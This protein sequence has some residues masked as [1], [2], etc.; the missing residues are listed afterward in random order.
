MNGRS[1]TMQTAA[2]LT[3]LMLSALAADAAEVKVFTSVALTNALNELAPEHTGRPGHEN[4]DLFRATHIRHA[5]LKA[6]H[7]L[8]HPFA[9][10]QLPGRPAARNSRLA[11]IQK[12][13]AVAGLPRSSCVPLLSFKSRTMYF[14]A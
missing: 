10:A 5:D 9:T 8:P 14:M 4:T 3:G 6:Q 7:S 11:A 1:L 13:P 2:A 12:C